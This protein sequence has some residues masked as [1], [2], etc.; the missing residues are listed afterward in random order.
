MRNL[1]LYIAPDFSPAF[2][3]IEMTSSLTTLQQ[4]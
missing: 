4:F 2:S 1:L 3:E